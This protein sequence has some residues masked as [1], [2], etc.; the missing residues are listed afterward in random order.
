MLVSDYLA[1][2]KNGC[3]TYFIEFYLVLN[4][5]EFYLMIQCFDQGIAGAW[6][7]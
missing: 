1:V 6:M 5:S 4:I 3:N 7:F 2:L